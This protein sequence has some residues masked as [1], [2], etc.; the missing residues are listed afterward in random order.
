MDLI[1]QKRTSSCEYESTSIIWSTL[2]SS[3]VQAACG[4]LNLIRTRLKRQAKVD[5]KHSHLFIPLYHR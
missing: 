3:M 1:L 5:M 4:S 2:A